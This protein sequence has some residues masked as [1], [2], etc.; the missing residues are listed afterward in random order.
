MDKK[1]MGYWSIAAQKH[2]KGFMTDSVGLDE[3]DDIDLAGKAGRFIGSIRGNGQINNIKKIE[4]IA[5]TVG[6]KPKELHRIILPQIEIATDGQIELIKNSNGD[7]AGIAEYVFT[8]DEVISLTGDVFESLNPTDIEYATLETLDHTK[9][10]PYYTSELYDALNKVGFANADIEMALSLQEQFKLIQKLDRLNQHNPIISNEYVWGINHEKIAYALGKISTDNRQSIKEMIEEI[11][12]Y[13]GIPTE[14]IKSMQDQLYQLAI[15]IGMLNPISIVSNRGF[16]KDFVFSS[17]ILQPLT[18]NDDIMDDVKV[19]LA[20]V[21]F[22]EKYTEYSTIQQPAQFLRAL[23]NN[24]VGPHS[25][26]LTDYILLEKKGIVTV[27]NDTKTKLGVYGPYTRSGPC[28]KLIKKD[29]A[30]KALEIVESTDYTYSDDNITDLDV[31]GYLFLPD[32]SYSVSWVDCKSGN[33]NVLQHIGWINGIKPQII[34]NEV[35][36]IKQGV[37]KNIKEYARTLGIKIFELNSLKQLESN[38][39]IKNDDWHGGYDVK[40]QAKKLEE[41][42]K[43]S[44]PEPDT[45]KNIANFMTSTYWT[46]DR[47]SKVKKCIT[48]IRQ[49]TKILSLPFNDEQRNAI[50]WAIYNLV[51]LFFLATLEICGD[52]YYFSD[53][54]KLA[55]IAEGLVSGTIPLAKRQ[56]LADISHKIAAEVIKQYIPE[57]NDS[58]LNKVNPNTPPAYY[59]AYYDLI[60]RMAQNPLVWTKSLRVL[61]YVLM[62]FDLK[63]EPIPRGFFTEFSLAPEDMEFSLKTLLHFI[64]KVTGAPKN[65]FC[66]IC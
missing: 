28:L 29:I 30:Q 3:Y 35:I 1:A 14:D 21:R 16:E 20:S 58:T 22:G 19:L 56:E 18:P 32:F 65:L 51:S 38:Y 6:I 4:K 43:I 42:S 36:F 41:F 10:V 8:G 5:N 62:E 17:N 59:E 53:E 33:A 57:F 24:T 37:R 7:I 49:L 31:Y 23:L 13:Q 44:T 27:V 50:K 9:K 48:G 66:L 26:N 12:S 39:N 15:K 64:N 25:A 63:N 47:Y 52:V 54:D 40:V 55:T 2:L 46:L 45:Y 60:K 34:A 11:Q 61:D